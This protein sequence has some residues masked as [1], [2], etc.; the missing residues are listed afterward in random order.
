MR[1][2]QS[3]LCLVSGQHCIG[4]HSTGTHTHIQAA[5]RQLSLFREIF[6]PSAPAPGDGVWCGGQTL[7]MGEG[8]SP[9]VTC[10][11]ITCCITMLMICT[12][13]NIFCV[14]T[15]DPCLVT[16]SH[17]ISQLENILHFM[18]F[19]IILLSTI[20]SVLLWFYV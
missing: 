12:M 8:W 16:L 20:L 2:R 7:D 1:Q 13:V 3:L 5:P 15:S 17:T 9:S 18:I 10:M 6:L 4:Q 11:H 14:H 19:E